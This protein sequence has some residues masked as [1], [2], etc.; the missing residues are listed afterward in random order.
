MEG[1]NGP[2]SNPPPEVLIK[3]GWSRSGACVYVEHP[4][5]E[6]WSNHSAADSAHSVCDVKAK[7]EADYRE[8]FIPPMWRDRC[9]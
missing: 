4:G 9:T 7:A 8:F 5:C 2:A 1:P 6:N 3:P